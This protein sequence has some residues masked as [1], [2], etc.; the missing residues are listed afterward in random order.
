MLVYVDG[1]ALSR[2]V[3][4]SP[5][6]RQWRAWAA[7]HELSFVSSPLGFFELRRVADRL[8]FAGRAGAHAVS[9]RIAAVRFSDQA[10]KTAAMVWTVLSPFASLHLGVAISDPDIGVVATYD[11]LLARV[12]AIYGLSVVSPGR[13]DHWW[14]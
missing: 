7:V 8:G 11:V 2:Y 3:I 5:E 14:E 12:A 6:S 1:S 9:E 4:D 13:P 10:I